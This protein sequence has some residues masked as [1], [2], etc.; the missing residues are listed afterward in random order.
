MHGA[1][2]KGTIGFKTQKILIH[3][4]ERKTARAHCKEGPKPGPDKIK[5]IV[6][7]NPQDTTG[8]KSS[9]GHVVYYRRFI[10]GFVEISL[11]FGK[12]TRG[13]IYMGNEVDQWLEA[14]QGEARSTNTGLS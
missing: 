9:L 1:L 13:T 2:S 12:L 4:T 11:P 6:M 10:K 3:G 8:V 5:V 14:P 7:E